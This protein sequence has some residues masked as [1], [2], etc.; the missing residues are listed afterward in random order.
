M[1]RLAAGLST[2]IVLSTGAAAPG[3]AQVH[4]GLTGGTNG[5]GVQ[6]AAAITNRLNARVGGHYFDLQTKRESDI[7]NILVDVMAGG[8]TFFVSGL[9]DL[10]PFGSAGTHLTAGVYYNGLEGRGSI[11]PAQNITV[12]GQSYTPEEVGTVEI[13]LSFDSEVAPYV[14][15]GYGDGLQGGR[16][17]FNFDLGALRV[18]APSVEM[19][20]SGMVA[21]TAQQAALIEGNLDWFEWYPVFSFG[22]TS[23]IF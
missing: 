22:F 19:R 15:I 20:G 10:Y 17:A 21:P 23:R 6:V 11:T 9:L 2:L 4:A 1:R 3:A 8:N 18:G 16:F 13:D 12:Q 5:I 14:G 7:D